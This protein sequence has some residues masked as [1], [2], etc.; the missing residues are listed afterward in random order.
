MAAN[1]KGHLGPAA[2][3]ALKSPRLCVGHSDDSLKYQ[4]SVRILVGEIISHVWFSDY[5][6][7]YLELGALKAGLKLPNG[8]VGNPDGEFTLFLGYDWTSEVSGQVKTRLDFHANE[9]ERELFVA[10][11]H[12]AVI[13]SVDLITENCEI[14]I[15]LSTG[16]VLRTVSDKADGPDWSIKFDKQVQGYLC[17]KNRK[18]MFES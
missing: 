10:K 9:S 13:R 5:S 4:P 12:N 8:I 18:L 1:N 16:V 2:P 7:C 17:V 6:I 3:A 11:L 14:E 15:G